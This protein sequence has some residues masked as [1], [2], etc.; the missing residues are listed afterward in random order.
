MLPYRSRLATPRGAGCCSP[1][2][3]MVCSASNCIAIDAI[4][5]LQKALSTVQD[6]S[7]SLC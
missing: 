7:L 4:A 2:Y 1:C 5:L 6:P 3:I